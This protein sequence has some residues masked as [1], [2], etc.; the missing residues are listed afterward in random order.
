MKKFLTLFLLMGLMIV[1]ACKKD[2]NDDDDDDTTYT[3]LTGDLSTQTL[4]AS[5]KY[6]LKGQVFVR[7]GQTL[8]IEPGTVIFGDKVT[9]A[10]LVIDKGGKLE[11]N[12]T[13]DKP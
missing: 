8:T 5:N 4:V 2:N 13:V 3:E 6:L 7:N 1:V 9:R 11:A 12:G 10:I